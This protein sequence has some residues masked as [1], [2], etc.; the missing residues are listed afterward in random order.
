VMLTRVVLA[1]KYGSRPQV[2]TQ[3][4]DLRTMLE[5]TDAALII[6]D[7]ALRIEPNSLPYSAYDLGAEWMDMTGLPMVF[8]LWSGPGRFIQDTYRRA[9]AESCRFGLKHLDDIVR[10][11][12]IERG[13]PEALVRTYLTRHIEFELGTA[14][15]AGVE[16]FRQLCARL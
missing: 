9:F 7:P 14:H 16:R 4:P 11:S 13:Y 3:A 5:S 1:E 2:V 8:A 12:A 10:I 15:L 6:G